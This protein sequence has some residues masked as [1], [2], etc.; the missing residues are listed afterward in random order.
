MPST[1]RASFALYNTREEVDALVAGVREDEAFLHLAALE[2]VDR[3]VPL[4][5]EALLGLFEVLLPHVAH[6]N[7]KIRGLGHFRVQ[8]LGLL[9]GRPGRFKL[10][11]RRSERRLDRQGRVLAQDHDVLGG[12]PIGMDELMALFSSNK[13]VWDAVINSQDLT[14]PPSV[15]E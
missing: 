7:V 14:T 2:L 9:K 6:G 11:G 10:P 3:L 1:V 13:T 5:A 8:F 12:N 15:R 4:L